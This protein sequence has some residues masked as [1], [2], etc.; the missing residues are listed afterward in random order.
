MARPLEKKKRKGKSYT[1]PPEIETAIEAALAQDLETLKRCALVRDKTSS[2]YLPSECLVHLIRHHL[3]QSNNRDPYNTAA[4]TLLDLLLKRCEAN[5]RVTVS[6]Q[7]ARAEDI[8]E[9]VVSSFGELFAEDCASDGTTKLDYYEVRF[10]HAFAL[11]RIDIVRRELK[12]LN[13]K[14]DLTSRDDD[15][16]SEGTVIDTVPDGSFDMSVLE[17]RLDDEKRRARL[18]AALCELTAMER[19]ALM[20]HFS[21]Y[22]IESTNPKE[23]TVATLCKVSGRTIRTWLAQALAKLSKLREAT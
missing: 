8:R 3:R 19:K 23:T 13:R 18:R 5:L 14:A 2:E 22:K 15:D 11:F 12:Q 1:R 17:D 6:S 21:G 10:N 4:N 7:I 9:E 16:L 20:L